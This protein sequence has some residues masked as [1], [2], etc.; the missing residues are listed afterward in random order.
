[1]DIS[2]SIKYYIDSDHVQEFLHLSLYIKTPDIRAKIDIHEPYLIDYDNWCTLVQDIKNR[3][4]GSQF[5]F[6]QGNGNGSITL[7]DNNIVFYA[8]PSG[9][10]GDF[11]VEISTEITEAIENTFNKL[12]HD[13]EFKILFK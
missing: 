6:Y 2:Y 1:M 3:K 7:E 10:G 9:A 8:C 5:D 4:C 11:G 13:E 12:I